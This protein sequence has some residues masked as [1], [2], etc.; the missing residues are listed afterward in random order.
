MPY[1]EEN[2]F[3]E[4][5][6]LQY[7]IGITWQCP[8]FLVAGNR[9]EEVMGESFVQVLPRHFRPISRACTSPYTCP[10]AQI[11]LHPSEAP[12]FWQ[13]L[14][15][16]YK[17]FTLTISFVF[18]GSPGK[19][20]VCLQDHITRV[21]VLLSCQTLPYKRAWLRLAEKQCTAIFS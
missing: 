5:H 20:K 17:K 3:L 9:G 14:R 7:L 4:E 6:T 21:A 19:A 1:R 2:Y 13:F 15:T 18:L 10:A 16:G 11:F 8:C 12:V